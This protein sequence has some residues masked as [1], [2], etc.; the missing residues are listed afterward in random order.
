MLRKSTIIAGVA[1]ALLPA[2]VNAA[3]YSPDQTELL[4]LEFADFF[5]GNGAALVAKDAVGADAAKF[6]FDTGIDPDPNFQVGRVAFETP[7]GTFNK[8]FTG[9]EAFRVLFEPN[10]SVNPLTAQLFVRS[11]AGEFT[12]SGGVTIPTG[13]QTALS[14]PVGSIPTESMITSFGIEFFSGMNTTEDDAMVTATT[15]PQPPDFIETVLWSFE[16]P[17]GPGG[18]GSL[19]GWGPSFQPDHA[20]SV[21]MT[22]ATSGTHS[23]EV[24]RTHTG[25]EFPAGSGNINFR[26]GSQVTL[27]AGE[28]MPP[29][30]DYNDNGI[31]EAAD[32][33]SFRDVLNTPTTLPNDMTPGTV[34]PE[35]YDVW[36]ANF[37]AIGGGEPAVQTRIDE[38]IGAINTGDELAFD[39]TYENV[40]NFPDPNPGFIIFHMFI[41]DGSGGF[42]QW[43]QH[44]LAQP[45]IGESSTVTV[46]VP[47][48]SFTDRSSNMFQ[49]LDMD[50]LNSDN[51]IFTMGL[52]TNSDAGFTFQTDNIRVRTAVAAG[53]GSAVPE[54]VSATLLCCAALLLGGLRAPRP[55]PRLHMS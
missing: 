41:Q 2:V 54:P 10:M 37:G 5:P 53:L 33:V 24:V 1:V 19:E 49:P 23:M 42:W 43:D 46:S 31:V 4:S 7:V 50:V 14:I 36:R 20:H 16:G 47:F 28:G 22:G 25:E 26:W 30:G 39:I 9:L 48:S 34:A 29:F 55:Q 35:D 45:P 12:T 52:A 51:G 15:A 11:G 44:V 17:D 13:T 6:T 32:Y 21:S 8:D 27:D 18:E 3:I 38:I 40:D